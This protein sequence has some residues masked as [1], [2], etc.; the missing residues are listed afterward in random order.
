MEPESESELAGKPLEV[1][2]V[3]Q[4]PEPVIR[5]LLNPKYTLEAAEVLKWIG[6]PK[7]Q[8]NLIIVA[9]S[10]NVPLETSMKCVE[11][12]SHSI[13]R[14]GVL[15]TTGEIARLYDLYNNTRK[16]ETEMLQIRGAVLD[17]LEQPLR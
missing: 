10:G 14:F 13:Q 6:T 17:A 11:A 9:T 4:L 12:L 2:N 16:T 1:F 3:S 5:H 8:N 7:A 15:L